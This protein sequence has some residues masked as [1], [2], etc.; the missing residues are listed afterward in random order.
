LRH[1]TCIVL[2][3]RNNW[4]FLL[5]KRKS[6]SLPI[7]PGQAPVAI[8]R[9]AIE[10]G[11][12]GGFDVVIL[13]T[14]GRLAIDDVLMAEVKAIKDAVSPIETLLVADAM[15]GQDAIRVAEAFHKTLGLTGITLT[16]LDGDGR[17]GAALSMRYATGCRH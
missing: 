15:T 6:L 17:G 5:S 16:R 13:D 3:L 8:A 9:R 7:V 1:W 4:L 11:R 14:A 12:L 2:P 10:A